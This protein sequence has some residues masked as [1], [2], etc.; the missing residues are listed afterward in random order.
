MQSDCC[1]HLVSMPSKKALYFATE[2]A[3]FAV[4]GSERKLQRICLPPGVWHWCDWY[5]SCK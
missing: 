2:C 4:S 3:G 5:M 1:I